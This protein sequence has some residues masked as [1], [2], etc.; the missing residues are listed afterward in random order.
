MQVGPVGAGGARGEQLVGCG[1]HSSQAC[2]DQGVLRAAAAAAQG[3]LKQASEAVA[4][5]GTSSSSSGGMCSGGG[6]VDVNS[7]VNVSGSADH[8][9]GSKAAGP[10]AAV[11]VTVVEGALAAVPH[12][13]G[14]YSTGTAVSTGVAVSTVSAK[15]QT[16][17]AAAA[18][19][20]AEQHSL[21]S[22]HSPL[23][24]TPPP[25]LLTLHPVVPGVLH[26]QG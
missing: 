25:L 9:Q 17:G 5:S 19:R 7:S 23:P 6:S 16:A 12:R 18:V 14:T 10:E 11:S 1:G 26:V 20:A 4:G 21:P 13:D 8:C 3:S 22:P 2:D 15:A 24:P